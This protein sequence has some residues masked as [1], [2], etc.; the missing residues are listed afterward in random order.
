VLKSK[1]RKPNGARFEVAG[2]LPEGCYGQRTVDAARSDE[3]GGVREA[4]PEVG[5]G[6]LELSG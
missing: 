4:V 2:Q 1:A 5:L 3:N 6:V